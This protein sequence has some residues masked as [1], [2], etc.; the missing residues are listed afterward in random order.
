MKKHLLIA[1]VLLSTSCFGQ[2]ITMTDLTTLC[3]KKDIEIV[4][5]ILTQKG[6]EYYESQKGDSENFNTITWS[7]EKSY[8][9]KAQSWFYLYTN[10]GAPEKIVYTV[11]NKTSYL[12]IQ[13]SIISSGFKLIK[14][15]INDNTYSS[16]Y[17]N[18]N[19]I[20]KVGIQKGENNDYYNSSTTSYIF[21]IVKKNSAYDV[22][23]GKKYTYFDNGKIKEE[24]S[25]ING[26]VNGVQKTYY[27]NGNV[28]ITGNYINEKGNGK[29]YEYDENGNILADYAMINDEINGIFT[30]YE[31]GL[32]SQEITKIKGKNNGLATLYFYNKK[33]DLS[34]K[35]IGNF[36]DDKK[37]GKWETMIFQNS[38]VIVVETKNYIDD[39][40]NGYFKEFIGSDT[41][42]TK[43]YKNGLLDG[44]Y[45]REVLNHWMITDSIG[46][47]KDASFWSI[48]S[49][50]QYIANVQEGKWSYYL[51]G[52]KIS[53]GNYINGLKDGKWLDYVI[54]GN[55]S[56]SIYSETEYNS[57]VKHGL[58]KCYFERQFVRDT[59]SLNLSLNI[60]NISIIETQYYSFGKKNGEY[61]LKDSLG[62]TVTTGS[63]LNDLKENIWDYYDPDNSHY[64][65][66][67]K[68][69]K[70]I[71]ANNFD[72]NNELY[73]K[74]TYSNDSLQTCDFF[75]KTILKEK[76]LIQKVNYGYKV[77]VLEYGTFPND[78]ISSFTYTLGTDEEY[79]HQ[80]FFEKAFKDGEYKLFVKNITIIEGMY[81]QDKKCSYWIY[82]YPKSNV[83]A[84]KYY[85]KD[86]PG[87]EKY[88]NDKTKKPY[89][90]KLEIFE[91]GEKIIVKIKNG[92]K[93][94]KTVIFSPDGKKVREVKYKDGV[95]L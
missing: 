63:Y 45:K 32:K 54:F 82:N 77:I 44:A 17:S 35:V 33:G 15:E 65:I 41:L 28:Q 94:G 7:F 39:I 86:T 30:I 59:S 16:S 91:N 80:Q 90:G 67:Y 19:F 24:Y 34:S 81:C 14:S 20:L 6:W 52:N 55:Q 38:K 18:M 95:E 31:N 25:L 51:Q 3:C 46:E 73:L 71:V 23:N 29:F 76:Y 61:V 66:E 9:N 11:Y 60:V 64:S 93:N 48:E 42:E 21:W 78:S 92:L 84:T 13:N 36:I 69:N 70:R 85:N 5:T 22:D 43:Q 58:Y 37:N 79:S 1:I 89:N 62:K 68:N 4:N 87:E 10:N 40:K 88:Y 50:G 56:G 2:K 57:G 27:E 83:Y 74:E 47:Y 53:E 8:D 72:E 26:K 12:I 49:E 75:D